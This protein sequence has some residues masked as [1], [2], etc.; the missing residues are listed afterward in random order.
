MSSRRA[1]T[2]K[3]NERLTLQASASGRA[4]TGNTKAWETRHEGMVGLRASAK[5]CRERPADGRSDDHGFARRDRRR[6][7]GLGGGFGRSLL[8]GQDDAAPD[9]LWARR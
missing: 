4:S 8:Q 2:R 3:E 9:R 6:A 5:T 7:P 1:R